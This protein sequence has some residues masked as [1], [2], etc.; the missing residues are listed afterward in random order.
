[1]DALPLTTNG[2]VD[3]RA[4]PALTPQDNEGEH[5]SVAPRTDDEKALARIW[6][7]LL[8]LEKIGVDDEFFALGGHSLLAI[9]ALSR[10]RDVFGV[11]VPLQAMFAQPTI[12]G[13]A[14]SLAHAR[15]ADGRAKRKPSATP[16]ARQARQ[17]VER[18]AG[19]E[20]TT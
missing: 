10:I 15:A 12:A 17:H 16:I 3:R 1:L 4:L 9:R 11:E 14:R 13:L 2:K 5:Q 20:L 6:S 8:K 7:E 18:P 19:N